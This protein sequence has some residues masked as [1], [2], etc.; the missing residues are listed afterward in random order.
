MMQS[1]R[2]ERPIILDGVKRAVGEV[3]K[4]D[5]RRADWSLRQRLVTPIGVAADVPA[6][7]K[8]KPILRRCCGR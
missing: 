3:V 1:Y 5:P 7:V 4:L 2:V 6:L 8:P